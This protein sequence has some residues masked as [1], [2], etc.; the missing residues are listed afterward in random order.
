ML[1][2]QDIEA[3]FLRSQEAMAKR[4]RMKKYSYSHRVI[5]SRI[6]DDYQGNKQKPSVAILMTTRFPNRVQTFEYVSSFTHS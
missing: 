5:S 1:S 3:K 6:F 2:K 4:E